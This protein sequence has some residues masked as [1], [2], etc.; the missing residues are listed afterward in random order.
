MVLRYHTL[1]DLPKNVK[2]LLLYRPAY[3]DIITVVIEGY[4]KFFVDIWVLTQ[5]LKNLQYIGIE[6]LLDMLWN[7]RVV[8]VDIENLRHYSVYN[9]VDLDELRSFENR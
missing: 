7:S 6:R 4:G 1:A 8:K 2:H 5:Y 3:S 9:E